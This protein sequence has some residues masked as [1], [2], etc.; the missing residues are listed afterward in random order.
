MWIEIRS[1]RILLHRAKVNEDAPRFFFSRSIR[2][3]E[4]QKSKRNVQSVLS[5]LTKSIPLCD[6]LQIKSKVIGV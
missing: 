3:E 6:S 2:N 5:L 4:K 1:D